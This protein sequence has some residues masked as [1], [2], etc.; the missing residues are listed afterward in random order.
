MA[1]RTVGVGRG[2]PAERR[3]GSGGGEDGLSTQRGPGLS[4]RAGKPGDI[5]KTQPGK[6]SL[7]GVPVPAPGTVPAEVGDV[8]GPAPPAPGEVGA[9]R[10]S[11]NRPRGPGRVSWFSGL[12]Y[13]ICEMERRQAKGAFECLGFFF[14]VFFALLSRLGSSQPLDRVGGRSGGDR[15]CRPPADSFSIRCQ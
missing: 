7:S 12:S 13:C 9:G 1:H 11:T 2:G 6:R 10:A 14:F 15:A 5:A 8:G 4:P 3:P